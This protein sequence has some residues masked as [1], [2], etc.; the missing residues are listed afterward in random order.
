MVSQLV[1]FA[2]ADEVAM[3]H[4][5]K[6]A[7]LRPWD[8]AASMHIDS[9]NLDHDPSSEGTTHPVLNCQRRLSLTSSS[10]SQGGIRVS[11]RARDAPQHHSP[12]AART[13]AWPVHYRQST[14]SDEEAIALDE[15]SDGGGP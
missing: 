12:Q 7:Y 14:E 3:V 6:R 5:G 4:R 9:R 11:D 2:R 10:T 13:Q 15:R 8:H 1:W